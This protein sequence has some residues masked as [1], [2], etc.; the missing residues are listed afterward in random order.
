M[1]TLDDYPHWRRVSSTAISPDGQWM[2]YG[3]LPDM[4]LKKIAITGGAPVTLCDAPLFSGAVWNPDNT[5]VYTETGGGVKQVSANGGNPEILIEGRGRAP[6]LLPNGNSVMFMDG[7]TQ[8]NKIVVQSLESGERKELFE[9]T[10]ARYLPT[11]H[12]VY[13]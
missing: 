7:T 11:G 8:P 1:L 13:Q 12:I 3:T 6:Q 5:I 10:A 2:G 4:Q 9:G